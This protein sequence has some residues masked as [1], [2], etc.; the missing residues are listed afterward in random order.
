MANFA[1]IHQRYD[2]GFTLTTIVEAATEYLASRMV[3]PDFN[4]EW[5]WLT[6]EPIDLNE[7][8]IPF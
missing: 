4:D 1:V 8:D 5:A 6:T 7:W 3:W 2:D